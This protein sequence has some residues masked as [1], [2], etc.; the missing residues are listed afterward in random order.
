MNLIQLF[1]NTFMTGTLKTGNRKETYP[2]PGGNP[3]NGL[4]RFADMLTG[5]IFGPLTSTDFSSDL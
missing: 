3:G 1:I 4:C 2:P 5:R